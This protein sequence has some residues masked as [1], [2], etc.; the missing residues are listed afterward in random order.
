M[1]FR[2]PFVKR[3]AHILSERCLSCLSYPVLGLSVC[4]CN[5]RW[6]IVG[7]WPT[8]TAHGSKMK[9]G[10]LEG[11]GPGHILLDGDP[12]PL[13]KGAHAYPQFSAHRAP[14]CCG[15][16]AGW[17]TMPLGR[18]LGL[19]PISDIVLDGDP[20]PRCKR[21]HSP[22]PIFCPRLLWPNGWMDQAATSY[23]G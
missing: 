7:L 10:M 19:D 6:C 15:Q 3:F 1:L 22:S 11:L 17:I 9:L 20:A 14:T 21:G 5:V 18:K 2:R 16:M 12:S 13:P 23:G 8:V 4:I